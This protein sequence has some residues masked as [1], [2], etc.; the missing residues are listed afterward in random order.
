MGRIAQAPVPQRFP[1]P[2]LPGWVR[3]D[4][5]VQTMDEAALRAGAALATLDARVRAAVTFAG[6]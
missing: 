4:A 1:L 2:H 3:L 5:A 6:V